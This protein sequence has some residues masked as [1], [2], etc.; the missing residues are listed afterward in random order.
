VLGPLLFTL[1]ISP[2]AKVINSFW[3]NHA[4]FVDD[5]QLY[6]ALKDVN[7]TSR[8]SE[9]F[10]AVQHWLD[11]NSLSMNPDKT[12]AIVVG[13]SAQKPME[14]L[15]NT[16]DFGCVSVSPVSNV[17]SSGVTIDDTLLFNK[18]VDNV[19]KSCNFHIRALRHIRRHISEDAANTQW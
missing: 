12:E 5:T 6:I 19:C 15:V 13:T 9:C 3:V 11:L 1:Y 10:C 8:Q 17:R 7:S 4:Q 2:L 18:H 16:V 14:G